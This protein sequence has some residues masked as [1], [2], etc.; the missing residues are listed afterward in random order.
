MASIK[1][2]GAETSSESRCVA[3][4]SVFIS[5]I[6]DGEA[7]QPERTDAQQSFDLSEEPKAAASKRLDAITDED[8]LTSRRHPTTV[9]AS[10]TNLAKSFRAFRVSRMPPTSGHSAPP[11][12]S[13]RSSISTT[14]G[15]WRQC[16]T[17]VSRSN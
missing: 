4:Y 13:W 3:T 16:A 10:L 9:S 2:W 7:K 12:G 15:P 5:Y 1:P 6:F 11:V 8:W 17:R 14:T